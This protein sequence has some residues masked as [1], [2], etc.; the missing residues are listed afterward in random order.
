MVTE[1]ITQDNRIDTLTLEEEE[2]V[3]SAFAASAAGR[4]LTGVSTVAL[5]QFCALDDADARR[6]LDNVEELRAWF[7]AHA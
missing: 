4:V 7:A 3:T 2:R 1:R 6:L 5:E